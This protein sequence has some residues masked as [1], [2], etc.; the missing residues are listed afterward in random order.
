MPSAR[1]FENAAIDYC[2]DRSSVGVWAMRSEQIAPTICDI[3]IR[4]GGHYRADTGGVA[5]I[6]VVYLPQQQSFACQP[7]ETIQP[8]TIPVDDLAYLFS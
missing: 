1:E 3:T 5:I 8:D 4:L 7:A 2:L 6:R